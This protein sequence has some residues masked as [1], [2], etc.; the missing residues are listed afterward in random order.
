MQ[1]AMVLQLIFRPSMGRVSS[2]FFI[3]FAP[4][5]NIARGNVKELDYPTVSVC[6]RQILDR[7]YRRL[8]LEFAA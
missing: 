7:L 4:V 6:T 2:F 8:R 5:R 1:Q 3:H